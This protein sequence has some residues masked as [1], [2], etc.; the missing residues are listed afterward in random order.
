YISYRIPT[1]EGALIERICRI[2][3]HFAKRIAR[4][5]IFDDG[6]YASI[7]LIRNEC[8]LINPQ[9][10]D[11]HRA[12]PSGRCDFASSSDAVAA[13][14]VLFPP[15]VVFGV[16]VRVFGAPSIALRSAFALP[17]ANRIA[18]RA[19]RKCR[20]TR[21]YLF[22][23]PVSEPTTARCRTEQR[24]PLRPLPGNFFVPLFRLPVLRR[25]STLLG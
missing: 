12:D 13:P 9:I 6:Q 11:R 10:I 16:R 8:E 24:F 1:V 4:I 17:L 25:K 7:A 23:P 5:R 3:V 22:P 15:L 21:G 2:P 19:S 20:S 14:F 18:R